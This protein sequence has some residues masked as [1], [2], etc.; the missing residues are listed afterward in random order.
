[1]RDGIGARIRPSP[2]RGLRF[3]GDHIQLGET[4]DP[5]ASKFGGH[6]SIAMPVDM[7]KYQVVAP[8]IQESC[9]YSYAPEVSCENSLCRE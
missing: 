9:L 4:S 6:F 8:D 3:M 5:E 1:M 2:G 7:E